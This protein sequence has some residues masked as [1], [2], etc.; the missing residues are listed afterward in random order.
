M[1][2]NASNLK[3]VPN[4]KGFRD[5]RNEG[6]IQDICLGKAQEVAAIAGGGCGRAFGCDVQP[7]RARCH[8]R[9]SCAVSEHPR[10]EWYGGAFGE[11]ATAALEAAKAV[12]GSEGKYK[13][14]KRSKK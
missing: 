6:F 4:E 13:V 2:G 9:A 5:F 10:D 14:K 7:G 12:G 11:A 8:A 3:F 1:K